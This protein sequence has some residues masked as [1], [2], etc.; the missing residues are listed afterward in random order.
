MQKLMVSLSHGGAI[1]LIDNMS[2]SS[3]DEDVLVWS[4]GQEEHFK[5]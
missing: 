2:S 5:V 4:E 3:F 1:K